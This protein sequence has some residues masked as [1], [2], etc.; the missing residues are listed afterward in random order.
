VWLAETLVLMSGAT[1][2]PTVPS[3][4]ERDGA[5][6]KRRASVSVGPD[7]G[8]RGS[9][10]T[11]RAYS[12]STVVSTTPVGVV[13][14]HYGHRSTKAVIQL[15]RHRQLTR[16]HWS[17]LDTVNT[18]VYGRAAAAFIQ[19]VAGRG[20]SGASLTVSQDVLVSGNR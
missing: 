4:H 1:T 3:G 16:R 7:N 10:Y 17:A 18:V 9:P 11:S 19:Q 6:Q 8:G 14:E 20:A 2:P 13:R 5:P 15:R 12:G